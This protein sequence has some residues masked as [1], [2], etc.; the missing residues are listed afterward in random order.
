MPVS[1]LPFSRS[2]SRPVRSPSRPDSSPLNPLSARLSAVT[3]CG[4]PPTVTPVQAVI[5]CPAVQ[6][7]TASPASVSRSPSNV[8]QS[9]TSSVFESGPVSAYPDSQETTSNSVVTTMSPSSGLWVGRTGCGRAAVR[10]KVIS[11]EAASSSVT[12]KV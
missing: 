3:R 2:S 1:E 4:V 7:S 9:P 11:V 10:S 5:A 8:S 12:V 6:L